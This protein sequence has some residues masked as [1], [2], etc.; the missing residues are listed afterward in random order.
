MSRVLLVAFLL[1]STGLSEVRAQP[2]PVGD[3][4]EDYARLLQLTGVLPLSSAMMRPFPESA[5]RVEARAP[6]A[7]P[8]KERFESY[9]FAHPSPF[10]TAGVF[11]ARAATHWNSNRPSGINDG[12][13]W[14]GKGATT[15]FSGGGFVRVGPVS[16]AVRP[17]IIHHQNA[18]FELA[19]Q[20]GRSRR[21]SDFAYPE[22]ILRID[23][24]QRFGPE[25][26]STVDWGQ[27]FVR[28]DLFGFAAGLS[29]ANMWWGP[30]V[31]NAIVMSNNAPGIGHVFVGTSEP[32]DIRIGALQ[33]RW[34]G[35][36]LYES[37]YFDNNPDN[38]RRFLNAVVIDYL[39]RWVPGL[40]FG[41]TRAFNLNLGDR[42]PG[43]KEIGVQFQSILK[44]SLGEDA[45][46]DDDQMFSVFGRWAMPESHFEIYAEWARGDH[47]WDLRDFV[48]EPEHASGFLFGFQKVF[49]VDDQS[50]VRVTAENIKLEA[51]RT[52]ALRS[53]NAGFFYVHHAVPQGYTHR[54]QVIGAGI[55]PGSNEQYLKL[56][57]IRP[58]GL[59]GLQ[60]S[61]TVYDEDLVY[62]L[63]L[64]SAHKEVEFSFGL[65]AL[66]FWKMLEVE[67]HASIMP[68]Y[69]RHYVRDE[70][71]INMAVGLSVRT[72][73]FG[74]R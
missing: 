29:K 52:V 72:S 36:Y 38:D 37:E 6:Q 17:T 11:D 15:S 74:L 58:W 31:R 27:S 16:A 20:T 40:S 66:A 61:R 67:G 45:D 39:P 9:T 71:E 13:A 54:G 48:L 34:V 63:G 56:D 50:Y 30:G 62:T 4:M 51:P 42:S 35:G 60:L 25:P 14:Q 24:P 41:G 65:H 46:P 12:A 59:A 2:I 18:E 23:L 69:N 43:W 32:Q 7:H 1:V 28:L 70:D 68:L 19:R 26:F 3:A 33:F 44:R 21:L 8:W 53:W 47:S 49:T 55:G 22:P 57:L 64:S 5:L 73:L 10:F